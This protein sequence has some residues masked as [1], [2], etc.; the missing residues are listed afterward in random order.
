[1]PSYAA[2]EEG[3]RLQVSFPGGG[4]L[5]PSAFA[6]GSFPGRSG[7]LK[8][9]CQDVRATYHPAGA[10]AGIGCRFLLVSHSLWVSVCLGWRLPVRA[11]LK[12]FQKSSATTLLIASVLAIVISS[13]FVN[14][15]HSSLLFLLG[16]M[17]GWIFG[18][19][20]MR[21]EYQKVYVS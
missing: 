3:R 13:C 8:G 6:A 20:H 9:L 16:V 14:W 2:V 18:H 21:A 10:D 4:A 1:M 11:S 19:C 15:G 7:R 12:P 17:E 5:V